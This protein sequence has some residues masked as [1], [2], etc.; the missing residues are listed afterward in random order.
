M[1]NKKSRINHSYAERNQFSLDQMDNRA[2]RG[3]SGPL[4]LDEGGEREDHKD[5]SHASPQ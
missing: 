2:E 4:V 5:V 3:R 1:L